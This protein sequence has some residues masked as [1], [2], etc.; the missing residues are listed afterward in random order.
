MEERAM[1]M[2]LD[3]EDTGID[4]A[5]GAMPFLV[6]T[7]DDSYLRGSDAEP[8]RYWEWPVNPLTRRPE[9]PDGDLAEIAELIDAADLIYL[10]NAKFDARALATVGIALPWSKVRDTLIASH[11]LASNHRHDLT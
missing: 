8:V 4:L 9:I 2:S 5:H 10:H 7:C 11:L 6:T 3:T 1:I